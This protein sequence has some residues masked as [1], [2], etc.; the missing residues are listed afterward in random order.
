MLDD[1]HPFINNIKEEMIL[2]VNEKYFFSQIELTST[3]K[4]NITR[5]IG[6]VATVLY[7]YNDK[8]STIFMNSINKIIEG[9]KDEKDS[10]IPP[11]GND[12]LLL[13]VT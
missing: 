7:S 3:A 12:P 6:A 4:R 11:W 10:K 1:N 8:W 13:L 9:Q 5:G 2:S